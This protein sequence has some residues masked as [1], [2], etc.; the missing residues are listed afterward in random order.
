MF[1][2]DNRSCSSLPWH[3]L[4]CT[5]RW[6]L[7]G[8]CSIHWMCRIK[9]VHHK[10]VL[11]VLRF[12]IIN[13]SQ[14]QLWLEKTRS[15]WSRSQTQEFPAC[16]HLQRANNSIWVLGL[17]QHHMTPPTSKGSPK[18]ESGDNSQGKGGAQRTRRQ[19][20]QGNKVQGCSAGWRMDQDSSLQT[21]SM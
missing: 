9:T 3:S 7:L 12:R 21:K 2:T 14:G 13:S 15:S 1:W 19:Q 11:S 4:W 20:C 6:G 17:P 16:S 8:Q 18:Q 5:C 10:A